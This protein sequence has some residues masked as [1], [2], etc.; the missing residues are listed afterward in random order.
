MLPSGRVRGRTT[1]PSPGHDRDMTTSPTPGPQ[2]S[3]SSGSDDILDALVERARAGELQAFNALVA[4]FQDGIFSLTLRMLGSSQAAED[5]TQDAFDPRE[6]EIIA[7]VAR[8]HRGPT[9]KRSHATLAPLK[10][11]QQ[12]TIRQLAALLRLADALDRTHASRVEEIYGSIRKDRV[13]LEV[14][15]RYDV[16]L[17]ARERGKYFEK[18]FD[19]RLR[20]RQGL[21]AAER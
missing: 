7:H 12:R 8:Y 5:A 3:T 16:S 14:V 11:W 6:M 9:P 15:S 1:V 21:E 4:R 20:L 19:C 2:R 13:T 17:E 10:P 18:V